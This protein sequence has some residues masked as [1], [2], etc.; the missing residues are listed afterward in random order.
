MSSGRPLLAWRFDH[1]MAV[2]CCLHWSLPKRFFPL[3]T[4]YHLLRYGEVACSKR[5]AMN[6]ASLTIQIAYCSVAYSWVIDTFYGDSDLAKALGLG[7]FG[8]AINGSNDAID[9][10]A[11]LDLNRRLSESDSRSK[12]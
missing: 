7:R 10:E 12:R 11:S 9:V 6:V 5:W 8:Q 2:T 4:Y 3:Q 1:S